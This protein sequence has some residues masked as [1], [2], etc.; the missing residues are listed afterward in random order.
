MIPIERLLYKFDLKLNKV[1]SGEHQNFDLL[2]KILFLREASI[3][4]VKKKLNPG[5]LGFDSFTLRYE[6]LQPLVV[7]YEKVTPTKGAGIYPN[8]EIDLSTL[9]KKYF[10]PV[11]IVCKASR[12]ECTGR[13]VEVE[14]IVKHSDL[15]NFLNNTNF[16]PS[17]LYQST[18]AEISNNK[19]IIYSGDF[20]ITSVEISYLKYPQ[21][22]NIVGIENEDGSA[23]TT[24]NSDLPEHLEDE[25]LSLAVMEA[26]YD[27]GNPEAGNAAEKMNQ[28]N[29]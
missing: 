22:V 19:L 17:F 24:V 27:S 23:S 8:Y 21:E 10:L 16:E 1:S 11:A 7:S 20:E 12:G 18:I 14:H 25:L 3:R 2:E 4:L 9:Q 13:T 28:Y 29:S 6:D 15:K 5:Q 26:A